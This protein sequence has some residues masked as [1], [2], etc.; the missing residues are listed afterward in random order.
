MKGCRSFTQPITIPENVSLVDGGF[1]QDC[2]NFIG[3][4]TVECSATKVYASGTLCT[5][6]GA[7]PMYAT[8]V[9]LL[10]SRAAEWKSK[11][12]NSSSNPYRKLILG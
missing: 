12:P 1:L 2:N 11:L 7:N 6:S 9:T 4:I 10:G 3:P 5:S 8:G